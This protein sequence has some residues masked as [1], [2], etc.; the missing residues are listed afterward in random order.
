MSFSW[1]DPHFAAL[2][3]TREDARLTE[4]L[5]AELRERAE[6]E[7]YIPP[8]AHRPLT[9][10]QQESEIRGRINCS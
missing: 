10:M 8:V 3:A 9:W 4:R 6:R 7:P 5:A 1:V 2:Y